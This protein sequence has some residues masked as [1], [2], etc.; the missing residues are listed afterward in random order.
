MKLEMLSGLI[1]R[2]GAPHTRARLDQ[3][4]GPSSLFLYYMYISPYCHDRTQVGYQQI[5]SRHW[6]TPA[7]LQHGGCFIYLQPIPQT[8]PAIICLTPFKSH[9]NQWTSLY[10]MA[11]NSKVNYASDGT[12]TF[13]VSHEHSASFIPV[14]LHQARE[15]NV[16]LTSVS[17]SGVIVLAEVVIIR[18]GADPAGEKCPIVRVAPPPVSLA[19]S[20]PPPPK[21]KI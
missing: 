12:H 4:K 5:P 10:R 13:F 20:A 21:K 2:T 6:L 9:L 7:E 17:I 1:D 14:R 18:E 8:Y 15:R 19:N 3:V 11:S 16:F